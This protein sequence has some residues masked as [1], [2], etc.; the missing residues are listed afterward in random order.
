MYAMEDPMDEYQMAPKV[1]RPLGDT[2]GLS[3]LRTLDSLYI[4][5]YTS[6]TEG[7]LGVQKMNLC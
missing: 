6:L 1:P 3:F 4:K 7:K 5:Q 2:N